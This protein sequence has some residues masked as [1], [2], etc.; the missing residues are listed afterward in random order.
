MISTPSN[1]TLS[2]QKKW[3][4]FL[5]NH[6][7]NTI[8]QSPDMLEFYREVKNFEPYVFLSF[9]DKKQEKLNGV[10]LV[11]L[12]REGKGIK[13]YFSSRAVIYGGP[14]IIGEEKKKILD[15]LLA[16]L[17]KKIKNKTVFIQFRNFFEWTPDEKSIFKQHGFVFRERLNLIVDTSSEKS[18][19]SGMS[20]SRRRQIKRGLQNNEITIT[21]PVD[22]SEVYI[23]YSLLYNLYKKKVKKPLPDYSFFLSFYHF[24]K[25]KKLGIIKLVKVNGKIIGGILSPVTKEKNIYEWYITGLNN[26]YKSYY[27]SIMATWASI[28]FAL[29]NNLD[30]FDFMGLGTPK[31]E[32]GVR[33]FKIRFGG[34]MVNY[35]RFARRN[36]K[37]LYSFAK[38]GFNFFRSLHWI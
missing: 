33:D 19:W 36:N 5:V 15:E 31:K 32:Y 18:F 12:I 21:D 28:E 38:F 23:F 6:P 37:Y 22:E 1:I 24:S 27:P 3:N 26:E 8:F 13:G 14:I 17:V 10:L 20:A 29:I 9:D 2:L 7:D 35:G 25:K 16:V 4:D 34:K 30:H 11:V